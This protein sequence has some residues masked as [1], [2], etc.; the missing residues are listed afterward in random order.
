M[1]EQEITYRGEIM[2]MAAKAG[3]SPV[4]NDQIKF[5]G[6]MWLCL[7]RF[8]NLVMEAQAMHIETLKAEVAALKGAN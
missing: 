4:N 3:V 6:P 2:E 8:A 5:E 1:T 7:E